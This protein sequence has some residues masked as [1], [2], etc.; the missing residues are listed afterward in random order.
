MSIDRNDVRRHLESLLSEEAQLLIE[1][2]A[3]LEQETDIVRGDD[4]DAIQRIGSN[5]HRCVDRLSRI[6]VERT[7]TVRMLC[8]SIDRTG[9]DKLIDWADP[10]AALRVRWRANLELAH[11]C[12]ALNDKNGAIVAAKLDRVQQLLGKLRGST[13]PPVYSPKGSRYGSLGPRALGCA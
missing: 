11:R 8:F 7:D 12:K 5:R 13:A 3:V 2:E 6:G 9:M 4:T 10:T 1:L